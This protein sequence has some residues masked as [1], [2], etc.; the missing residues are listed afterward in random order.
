MTSY[1]PKIWRIVD[2]LKWSTGYLREKG[3]ASPHVE[4]EWILRDVLGC[5]RLDVYLN[6]DRPMSKSEL[7]RFKKLLTQRAAG[8]PI[9]YVLGYTEFMGLTFKVSPA[10]LIPRPETEVIVE[11]LLEI[12]KEEGLDHSKICDIGTGSGN[13]AISLAAKH[14]DSSV[15]AIDISRKAL[16]IAKENADLN[17]VE[18]KV[19][20]VQMDILRES[21]GDSIPFDIVVSNPPY[22][23]GK[24]FKELPGIVK[25]YEPIEALHPGED[26][27]I[28]YRRIAE[29]SHVLLKKGGVLAVEIGG[30]YQEGKVRE[31]LFSYQINEMEVIKDYLGESRGILARVK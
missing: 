17:S 5:S 18:D 8:K 28:F 10:V 4:V 27:L 20:F 26:D 9:Q 13:I 22:V 24:W 21:P 1:T 11:R 23:T 25:M 2:V 3:S 7:A 19:K 31:V 16:K 29:L 6:Y 12:M 15:I 30:S 14:P